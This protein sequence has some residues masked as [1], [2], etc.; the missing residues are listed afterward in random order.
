MRFSNFVTA[1]AAAAGV[2]LLTSA[3]VSLADCEDG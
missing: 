1:I 2:L 3:D